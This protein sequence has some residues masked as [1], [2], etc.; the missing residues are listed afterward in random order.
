MAIPVPT[1]IAL[2]AISVMLLFLLVVLVVRHSG[3]SEESGEQKKR[4]R[5]Q[6]V[7]DANKKLQ[8]NPRDAEALQ[9][10]AESYF[11]EKEW[12]KALK[13]YGI[14][15]EL[16][17]SNDDIDKY[18]V[19][20]KHGLA[21]IQ[22]KRYEDAYESLVLA[23]THNPDSFELNYN[24]GFLEYKR[25]NYEKAVNLLKAAY[26]QNGEHVQTQKYLGQAYYRLK[27]YKE[28]LSTLRRAVDIQ[29]DD[30]ESL[31]A[32]AHTYYELGQADYAARI[33]SH[34]RADP[35]YGPRSALM[36]GSIHLKNRQPER[37]KTDFE[38]GLRHEKVPQELS[39]ELKYRL[40][41]AHTQL[42]QIEQA[43]PLLEEIYHA[44]PDYKDVK[45]QLQQDRELTDNKNLQTYLLAPASEFV[46]LCRRMTGIFFPQ[47]RVKITDVTVQKNEYADILADVETEQ[48]FDTI[49]FRYIRTTGQVGELLVREFH[50][51]IK[52]LKAERGFCVAAGSFSDG[53]QQFVE[54]RLIDL[55][56]KE[57]LMKL[58]S[59]VSS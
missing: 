15:I 48:W 34:L 20:L 52:E 59:K 24:L 13:T 43:L 1:L 47:S 56:E 12:E 45:E 55:V 10:L 35:H 30:K 53:A 6:S 40:A 29:P 58:L 28:A 33:F 19:N 21:A 44:N 5:T 7:K 54:A 17:A 38:V 37:A 14:L 8:Q 2:L 41:A 36:S 39:L 27:H 50:G 49:L 11:D 23:R 26:E 4:N 42:Q 32:M 46:S 3:S 18:E 57:D 51:R 31:F 9:T 16:S 25:K 22:L